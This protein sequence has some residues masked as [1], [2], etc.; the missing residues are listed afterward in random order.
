MLKELKK[1]LEIM[2]NWLFSLIRSLVNGIAR[3]FWPRIKSAD[4]FTLPV[5]IKAA[6]G[7]SFL[8]ELNLKWSVAQI[9]N[10]VAP[11]V[12][13]LADEISIIFAGKSLND[14]LLLEVYLNT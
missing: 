6:G 8:T 1:V 12:G 13:L 11:K 3:L 10:Y 14:S 2:L 7:K 5:Y 9:K 4:D